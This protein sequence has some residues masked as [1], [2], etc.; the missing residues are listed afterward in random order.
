MRV[1]Y[2]CLVCVYLCTD[3]KSVTVSVLGMSVCAL[4]IY[5]RYVHMCMYVRYVRKFVMCVCMICHLC[6]KV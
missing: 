1:I 5:A 3:S 2:V 6:E 4:R